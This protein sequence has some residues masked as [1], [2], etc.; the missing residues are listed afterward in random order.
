M[1]NPVTLSELRA[2]ARRRADMEDS[3]FVSDS[4]LNDWINDSKAELYDLIIQKYEDYYLSS[5]T[6]ST[7]NGTATYDL[8]VD[9][10][11]CRGVDLVDGSTTYSLREFMF[12]ERN[13]YQ[14]SGLTGIYGH[15]FLLY[16]ITGNT[17]RFVPTPT[18][19]NSITLWYI[20]VSK[21][22]EKD[23]DKLDC[24]IIPGWEE[25]IEIDVAM[26]CLEKEESDFSQLMARKQ[27]IVKRIEAA[28]GG[29][30][31]DLPQRVIDV[32]AIGS[33]YDYV[34]E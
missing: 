24:G 1:A 18:G 12:N 15:E 13:R 6:F 32:T 10:Y 9:F 21:K 28:S 23:S 27:L 19:V 17:I 25:Y 5:Y 33:I 30:N 7:A 26:K 3:A 4:D 14:S 16:R 22:L 34:G 11:K 8:P 20:P 2:K 29:R 31:S